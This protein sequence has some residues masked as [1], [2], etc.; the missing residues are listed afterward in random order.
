MEI[1]P[2]QNPNGGKLLVSDANELLART[3]AVF[4]FDSGGD[5]GATA[6]EEL[7]GVSSHE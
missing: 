4:F 7:A 1:L 3:L 5:T 6:E 2:R